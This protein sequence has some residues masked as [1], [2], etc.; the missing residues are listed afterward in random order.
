M[1][2]IIRDVPSGAEDKVKELAMI[3]VERF[4]RSRDVK[5]ADEVNDKFE[6]DVDTI[7]DA[8]DLAK[9]FEEEEEIAVE[10]K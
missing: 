5:V 1:D 6:S 8:N 7:R 3:A 2:V 4:L 10:P 9:K